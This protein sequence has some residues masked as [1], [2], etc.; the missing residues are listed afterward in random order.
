MPADNQNFST[1]TPKLPTDIEDKDQAYFLALFDRIFPQ[2]YLYPL[3]SAASTSG[4]GYEIW[5]AAAAVGERLSAMAARNEAGLT[6]VLSD[7][8]SYATVPVQFY[9]SVGTAGGVT[10][11]TGTVIRTVDGRQFETIADAVFSGSALGP[12]TVTARAIAKGYEYNVRGQRSTAAGETLEGDIS[13]IEHM[14]QTP[15]YGDPTILVRQVADASG[16]SSDWLD[17][18]GISRGKARASNELDPSYMSRI[19]NVSSTLTPDAVEALAERLLTPVFGSAWELV[20]LFSLE[21]QTCWDA[22]SSSASTPTYQAILPT[23]VLY[24]ETRFVFDD[25]RSI[26]PFRNR[27][28]DLWESN[29][30]FI[31]VVDRS[32]V[33][34]TDEEKATAIQAFYLELQKIKAAGV[35]G[36]VDEYHTW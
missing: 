20:E 31:V 5:R 22:P 6:I 29:G 25:P 23:T 13:I 10:V 11:N 33:G 30:A 16:G 8:G 2:E 1:V 26:V 7:G 36:I 19:R 4:S 18:H 14:R 34:P 24:D 21:Y 35:A 15:A 17:G 28:L 27:W 32:V 9:R 12:I 3:K